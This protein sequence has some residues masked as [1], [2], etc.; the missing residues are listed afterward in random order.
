MVMAAAGPR[1]YPEVLQGYGGDILLVG[2][3]YDKSAPAGQRKYTCK[4]EKWK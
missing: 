1:R 4:I 2:I 3:N